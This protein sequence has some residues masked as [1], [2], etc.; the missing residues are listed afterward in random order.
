VQRLADEAA[1]KLGLTMSPA[2]REQV[3]LALHHPLNNALYRQQTLE[4]AAAA[5]DDLGLTLGLYGNGWDRHP[6]LSRF[7]RGP[8]GYGKPLEELT[9]RSKINLQVVPYFFMHQ[10]LLD[11]LA[12]GGFFLVRLSATDVLMR[13]LHAFL[14]SADLPASVTDRRGA[15]A[16]LNPA[17]RADL[18][19]ILAEGGALAGHD[20]ID[21][22]E[23]VRSAQ[24]AGLLRG[25]DGGGELIPHL[26]QTGFKSADELTANIRTYLADESR[27]RRTAAEQ[28]GFLEERFTYTAGIGRMTRWLADKLEVLGPLA[29][30]TLP[31][32]GQANAARSAA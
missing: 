1:A 4:W 23:L 9:R 20:L 15:L 17:G 32:G 18:E 26:D 21:P 11:G 25:A 28:W 13:R 10:R 31:A 3:G 14:M 7:A 5:A 12:A 24:A 6:M 2:T 22:I 16:A 19:T 29:A 30:G 8:V 27:R